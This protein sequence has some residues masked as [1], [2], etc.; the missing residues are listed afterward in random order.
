MTIAART[1]L[2]TSLFGLALLVGLA[3]PGCGGKVV[4]D[5]VAETDDP[6][7]AVV[8][9]APVDASTDTMELPDAAEPPD[10]GPDA[11]AQCLCP[12]A[13]GYAPCVKPL[14]CCP[15]VG[16]CKNPASFNCTGSSKTCP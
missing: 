15:V 6:D 10:A 5:G 13:P 14:E 2:V 1:L 9:P 8:D 11:P 16:V 7:A 3:G 4:V 12:D